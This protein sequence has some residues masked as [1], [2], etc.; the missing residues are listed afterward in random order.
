VQRKVEERG[1]ATLETIEAVLSSG[2]T[3]LRD[4]AAALLLDLGVAIALVTGTTLLVLLGS[5]LLWR[6]E[7]SI[8]AQIVTAIDP[9]WLECLGLFF[10]G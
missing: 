2:L 7:K 5:D 4:V 9:A 1:D 6:S 3:I 8:V 10:S